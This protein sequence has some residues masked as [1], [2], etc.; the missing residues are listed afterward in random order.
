MA[1]VR[2]RCQPP[3]LIIAVRGLSPRGVR[4]REKMRQRKNITPRIILFLRVLRA[5]RPRRGWKKSSLCG[6]GDVA[7]A[8]GDLDF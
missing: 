7:A 5:H 8:A 4:E 2:R 1:A 6:R 3:V